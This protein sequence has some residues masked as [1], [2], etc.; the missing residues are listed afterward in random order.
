MTRDQATVGTRIRSLTT[1][2]GVPLGTEGVV[3]EQ[4]GGMDL[5]G[6][7]VG[8]VMIAWDLP[9]QPLPAGYRV[10]GRAASSCLGNPEGRLRVG[11][12]AFSGSGEVNPR[13]LLL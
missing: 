6:E 13:P 11:R 5:A 12:V 8:G 9:S 1:F 7:A 2:S 3:D 10:W 4:Y